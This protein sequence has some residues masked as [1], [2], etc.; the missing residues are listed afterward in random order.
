[1]A[2]IE[3]IPKGCDLFLHLRC[4]GQW[5]YAKAYASPPAPSSWNETISQRDPK[6]FVRW[7]L[8]SPV[9]GRAAGSGDFKA[10]TVC[11]LSETTTSCS[12]WASQMWGFKVISFAAL[13]C[14]THYENF[15]GERYPL[16]TIWSEGRSTK[17]TRLKTLAGRDSDEKRA[18]I[19]KRL[20]INC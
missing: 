13:K 3:Q 9:W 19:T 14:L 8:N 12:V 6:E 17:V 15:A 16:F 7:V 1:M 2:E 20:V 10:K 4:S 5:V 18:A 11:F